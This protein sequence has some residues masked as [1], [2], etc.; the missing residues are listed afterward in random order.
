MTEQIMILVFE[1]QIRKIMELSA[2]QGQQ[3]RDHDREHDTKDDKNHE[4]DKKHHKEHHKRDDRDHDRKH[5]KEH[6]KDNRGDRDEQIFE[7]LPNVDN[8]MGDNT[9]KREE[10]PKHCSHNLWHKI[11]CLISRVIMIIL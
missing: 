8:D 9:S 7:Y 5:D 1:S 11:A 2:W 4:H 6:D 10:K 3:Q